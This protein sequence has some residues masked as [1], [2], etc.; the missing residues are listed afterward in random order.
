MVRDSNNGRRSGVPQMLRPLSLIETTYRAFDAADRE[1]SGALCVPLC[2]PDCGK[3]CATTTVLVWDVEAHFVLSWLMGNTSIL[4]DVISTCEGWLLDRDHSLTT[5][6]LAGSLTQEQWDNLRPEVDTLLLSRP[7]PFLTNE[8]RCLIHFARPLA[9]RAYGI[10]HLP[11]RFC[12]RPLAKIETEDMRGH[13]PINSPTSG[14]L[15]RMV[16]ETLKS[17]ELM[18]W[19]GAMFLPTSIFA[20]LRPSIFSDYVADGKVAAAKLVR[21]FRNPAILFQD[22]LNLAWRE[23]AIPTIGGKDNV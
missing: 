9:C 16:S 22:E 11:A 20:A 1:L 7:C 13:I 19:A 21:L 18:G 15:R 2:I 23:N 4:P 12:P 10:T 6:G 8:K 14:K 17:S 5:Y 3:C